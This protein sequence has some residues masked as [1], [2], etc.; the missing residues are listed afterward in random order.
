MEAAA[1]TVEVGAQ[2]GYDLDARAVSLFAATFDGRSSTVTGSQGRAFGEQF[3]KSHGATVEMQG[4]F[5]GGTP[6]EKHAGHM[7]IVSPEHRLLLDPTFQQFRNLGSSAAPLFVSDIEAR[8]NGRFWQTGD[9]E[10]FVRYFA[11]DEFAYSNFDQLRV[12]IQP[13]AAEIADYV[14]E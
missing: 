6:F 3:L 2:L 4:E 8:A 5:T 1:V 13:K 9:D 12:A 10:F 7:V 11:A 14:R